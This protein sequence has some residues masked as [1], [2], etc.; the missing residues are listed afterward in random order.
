MRSDEAAGLLGGQLLVD[1]LRGGADGLDAPGGAGRDPD[2]E[3]LPE[4]QDRIGHDRFDVVERAEPAL[5][6]GTRPGPASGSLATAGRGRQLWWRIGRSIW[7]VP[8]PGRDLPTP[9]R[10]SALA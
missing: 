7:L 3:F 5:P 2:A 4:G 1:E 10:V 6:L 9:Q 8:V